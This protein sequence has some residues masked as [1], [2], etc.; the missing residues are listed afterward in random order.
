MTP[1][2]FEK[3]SKEDKINFMVCLIVRHNLIDLNSNEGWMIIEH[4]DGKAFELMTG[5]GKHRYKI[6]DK[7]VCKQLYAAVCYRRMVNK[8]WFN[9]TLSG[10]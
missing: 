6:V 9:A 8:T 7:F 4:N 2:K 5:D 1:R 3:L 10:I